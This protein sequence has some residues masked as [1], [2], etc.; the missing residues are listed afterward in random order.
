MRLPIPA[1]AALAGALVACAGTPRPTRVDVAQPLPALRLPLLGGGTWSSDDARGRVLVI[2]V[3][4]SWCAPCQKGFPRLDALAARRPEVAIVAISI[5][6]DEAAIRGFLARHPLGVP[7]AHDADQTVT[8]EPLRIER[9]PTLLVVDAEGVVRHRLV[10]P[11]DRDYDELDRLVAD[12]LAAP[13]DARAPPG[14]RR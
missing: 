6:D 2:D 4:A 3:W 11:T 12:L 14:P 1:L 10:E 13:S 5:D 8:A 9:L 7:V